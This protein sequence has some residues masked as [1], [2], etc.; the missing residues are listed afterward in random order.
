MCPEFLNE[1]EISSVGRLTARSL[2][3]D[4]VALLPGVA[5]RLSHHS[6]RVERHQTKKKRTTDSSTSCRVCSCIGLRSVFTTTDGHTSRN[7]WHATRQHHPSTSLRIRARRHSTSHCYSEW[8][9]WSSLRRLATPHINSVVVL[10]STLAVRRWRRG[11]PECAGHGT[12]VGWSAAGRRIMSPWPHTWRWHNRQPLQR[13]RSPASIV[14]ASSPS[15]RRGSRLRSSP[16]SRL[17]VLHRHRP[18]QS[19]CP[20]TD[21]WRAGVGPSPAFATWGHQVRR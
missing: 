20:R 10:S 19:Q 13:Q 15:S 6:F 16:G 2:P 12:M 1:R 17:R 14:G 4:L 9:W 5:L 18:T 3:V 7:C 8:K 11:H 21:L